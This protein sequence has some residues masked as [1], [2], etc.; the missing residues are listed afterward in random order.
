MHS[1][2]CTTCGVA[3]APSEA[4]PEVCR[5]CS[6]ERQYVNPAG[7][8]W[9]T[10]AALLA[11]HHNDIRQLEPGLLGI[12]TSP[13]VAIGQRALFVAGAGGGVLW[14]CTALCSDAAAEAIAAQGG[15]R[16]I[17]ISHPHFY[18][19]MVGWSERLGG[20][21]IYL[22][23]A[24]RQWVMYPHEN[25]V[26]WSG[27]T[28]DLGGGITLV[29]CGGHFAGSAVLHWAGGAE[30]RGALFTA[31][32]IMVTPDP[33]WMSFMYSYPISIP[34]DAATVRR[35]VG[36]VDGLAFDRMYGGWWDR[37]CARDAKA[38]LHASAERYIRAIGG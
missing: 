34:V 24:D 17:A 10:H 1:H 6:E 29:R 20:V 19:N 33:Q 22:H 12:G 13:A 35:I 4:P 30:G 38:R 23:E 18:S 9:T 15:M 31:D 7:Q 32:T 2:I 8:S 14:D 26:H 37:V 27:E 25:I 3:Y 11:D 36:A 5:I 16:A 28:L 21:P